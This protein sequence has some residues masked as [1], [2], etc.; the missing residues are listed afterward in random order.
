MLGNFFLNI[1]EENKETLV[2]V[3]DK[4]LLGKEFQEGRKKIKVNK[5]FYEGKR[6]SKDEVKKVMKNATILNLVG[7]KSV[8]IGI[9]LGL[10]DEKNVIEVEGVKHAQMC[11]FRV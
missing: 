7:N 4:G 9:G 10:I 1:I 11:I 5:R 8:S 3:C 6:A 2:A